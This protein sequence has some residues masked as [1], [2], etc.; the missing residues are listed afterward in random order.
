MPENRKERKMEIYK[1]RKSEH[2]KIENTLCMQCK[3][4]SCLMGHCPLLAVK[5]EEKHNE[6]V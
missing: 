5:K 1:S 6:K 4:Q 3:R 2:I